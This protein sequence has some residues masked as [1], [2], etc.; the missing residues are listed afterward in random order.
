[1]KREDV[2]KLIDGERYYQDNKWAEGRPMSD[3]ETPVAAWILYIETHLNLAKREIYFLKEKAALEH[4]RKLTALG[5]ACM[6]Y[7]DTPS[8]K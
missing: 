6:E 8:R 2:Y 7:N 4:I 3:A 5:V 1:M